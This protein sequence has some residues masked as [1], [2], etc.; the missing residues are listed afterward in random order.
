MRRSGPF[1]AEASMRTEVSL[2][3]ARRFSVPAPRLSTIATTGREAG[4]VP[5][6]GPY[7]GGRGEP[8]MSTPPWQAA[9]DRVLL[10]IQDTTAQ[11]KDAFPHWA[12]PDTG[13]WTTTPDGDWTGGYW[14]GM[15][16]LAATAT[17]E[18][19]YRDQAMAWAERLRARVE[20]ETGFKAFPLHYR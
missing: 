4:P 14:I 20:G 13:R 1:Q 12:D 8:A 17:G 2:I 18:A 11:V 6:L 16:W 19:R 15:L 3:G 9:I 5:R 7:T 10:R